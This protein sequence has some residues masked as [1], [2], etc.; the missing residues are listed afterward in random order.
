MGRLVTNVPRAQDHSRLVVLRLAALSLRLRHNWTT[1]FEDNDTA[2]IALA[3]ASIN[4][5]R[6]L[7]E[8]DLSPELRTLA[9][10]MPD[11]LYGGCNIASIATAAGLNRETTRRKI[12]KLEAAGIVQ[13]E[14]PNVRLA[15]GLS[16]REDLISL[17][18]A[19]LD[20][21]RRIADELMRDGVVVFE[22]DHRS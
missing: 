21:V 5:D 14:G 13:R 6:L 19:P 20:A 17:V 12:L 1:F 15:A 16:Q 18:R 11:E 7:R 8:E 9:T 4:A 10:P 3:I 22:D 2:A